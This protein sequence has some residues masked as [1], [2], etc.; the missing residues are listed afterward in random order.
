M[1]QH[2]QTSIAA[3]LV[4][5]MACGSPT[6]ESKGPPELDTTLPRALS[7]AE[8]KI[9]AATNV[10]GFNLL[11]EARKAEGEVNLF[12]SPL[13]VSLALG[14]TLN[15]AAGTTLDSM[16][17]ALGVAGA[18]IEEINAG[19]RNL[20]DLLHSLDAT[21][22]FEIAN[23]IWANAG[24][25]FLPAFLATGRTSFDAEVRSLDFAAP[26]T[27]GTI[28][29][30]VKTKTH[31][32]IEKIL[33][34]IS[35]EEVMFL[36]NAIYFKGSWRSA[37]D[38]ELTL[39]APF[40]AAD[41]TTQSVRTMSLDP[42]IHPYSSNRDLELVELPYGNGTFVMDIVLPRPD[43]TLADVTAGL[44]ASR[45][46]ELVSGLHDRDFGLRMPKFRMEYK[47][48]LKEDL[49]TLG[50]RVAFDSHR[51]NFANLIEDQ[52]WITK[53]QHKTY[54]DVNEEGTEA[55]AVTS[56][57]IGETSAPAT[58]SIDRPFLFLIRERLTG[59][60]LFVGQM[61]Q[62]P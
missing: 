12:I 44:D 9:S 20:I 27:L 26:A 2:T 56:V 22:Q 53:V 5:L 30:W 60:I 52:A 45:W 8:S 19:Y 11:R 55:A 38:P 43:R 41:G 40:H 46:A 42:E 37:F 10:L 58:L 49:S 62:V 25:A 59:T 32:K 21:S 51:A 3:A 50:M 61:T 4:L 31:G 17:I 6:G 23:S 57:G 36:I 39:D 16:R 28:N 15:G 35:A 47:R 18:P 54:V 24:T 7:A 33:D 48:S 34:E 1:H 29:D 14:M 13:S